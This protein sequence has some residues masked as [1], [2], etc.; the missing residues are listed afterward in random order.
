MKDSFRSI[1]TT[2]D[3]NERNGLANGDDISSMTAF[4]RQFFLHA[5]EKIR[6]DAIYF[7]RDSDGQAKVPLIYFAAIDNYDSVEIAK[8]HRLAWNMGDAPLLFVVTPEDLR[9]YCNYIS[10]RE[11]NGEL[12]SSDAL[13]DTIR[14]VDELETQRR[15]G[16]Y[17]RLHL[18]TGEL[19]R[20]S[21]KRF[22]NKSRVDITLMN[23]LKFM[24]KILISRI[25]TR[26]HNNGDDTKCTLSIVHSLL[27]RSILIKYLEER[28]DSCGNTVFPDGFYSSF[29]PG[30]KYYT[31]ILQDKEAT[32]RLF[33]ALEDKFNGD[34]F[35]LIKNEYDII[36]IDDL[37][38]LRSFILGDTVF[39]N[40]QLTLWPLY[41]FNVIPIQLISSI[42]ELF[43]H[44]SDDD[45][46]KNGTYYTPLHLVSVLMDEIYP[47]EGRYTPV[48]LLDP[49]CGSGIFLVEAYRRIVFR[50]INSNKKSKI[51]NSSLTA[52][53][54]QSIFGVDVNEEAIRVASFSL[55]LAMCD[56]LE[57][58]SIWE[59][60]V[61][62]KL[63]G[64]NLFIRDFFDESDTFDKRKYDFII[65][66]PPWESKITS[67]VQS[68]LYSR[69]K[70]IGDKQ[71]AQAFSL[72]SA[73]LVESNGTI[74]LLMPSKG[75]LF[76]RSQKT[77][78][79][80]N[81][82]FKNNSVG[83]II[84]FS[85]YR[86]FLFDHATGPAVGVIY[87][88]T[89]KFH[90]DA[91]FY[92]SPKP[93]YTIE[94]SLKFS[95][96][97]S[98]ICR[99]PYDL[100]WDERIWKVAMWG[101][102]RDYE[103]VSR[104][105]DSHPTLATFLKNH[106]MVN[107]E[108]FNEGNRKK[109]CD[110][111]VGMP[112]ITTDNFDD[113]YIGEDLLPKFSNTHFQVTTEKS[114]S[115]YI[116]PHLIL[117]QSHRNARFMSSVLDYNAVFNHSFF[118]IHG[119]P[120]YLSYLCLIFESEFFAYYH[121]M[122]NRRWLVE[123]DELEAGDIRST[124]IPTPCDS[125]LDEAVE[126][127]N[128]LKTERLTDELDNFVCSLYNLAEHEAKL[129]RDAFDSTYDLFSKKSKSKGFFKPNKHM[130]DSYAV[131]VQE[132][133]NNTSG[134]EVV[135]SCEFYYANSPLIV[136]KF[137]FDGEI[138][139]D[140]IYISDDAQLNNTLSHL[141]S[142]LLEERSEGIYIKRNVRVYYKNCA[143]IIK[144]A[145]SKYWNFSFACRDADDIF[146][147]VMRA[148]RE[149]NE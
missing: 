55:S 33:K 49:S 58:R 132:I 130:L 83:V 57:P 144:P 22:S 4:Q 20:T 77:S 112:Y 139:K 30:A 117:K 93:L 86:K 127:F 88:P 72:K 141:D 5:K 134:S 79:Y 147:D 51:S 136:A 69:K 138:Q 67:H 99:I 38:V 41:S 64:N 40:N 61:F 3:I 97:P 135:K 125:Q 114:R 104:I 11:I 17:N 146:S 137:N 78:I 42:Y 94:D 25:K 92:C 63:I 105:K 34:M 143:Y 131:S 110:D 21:V 23:N 140:S 90:S 2:L 82:F 6:V 115:I 103:L 56:F 91:I 109:F 129:V 111:F 24:R 118:G 75:F 52:L 43:F 28:T 59:E 149:T 89:Q 18:E 142:L 14:L 121:M 74:C 145:Q 47:W 68:Y 39:Q 29:Y 1:F 106:G 8:L 65:G 73:E 108:G 107:A 116:N 81:D 16:I 31:D 9:I 32:Y 126:L 85:A 50:W 100:I 101:N 66:N 80:R 10:P 13:I 76:N 37:L 45:Y 124:P 19:W 84:N 128:R 26:L 96:E 119:D 133:L 120:R 60:L 70:T 62:P 46:D 44:L 48:S 36:S 98:D 113:F 102:P 122:T 7:L 35:P 123:R 12:D 27:S 148:W 15:L 71:I 87:R 95:I 53:L 54:E